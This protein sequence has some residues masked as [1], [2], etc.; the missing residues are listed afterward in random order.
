MGGRV[1]DGIFEFFFGECPGWCV[2][3]GKKDS[4]DRSHEV[5]VV[6]RWLVLMA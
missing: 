4:S 2:E 5:S 1:K 3:R 6:S